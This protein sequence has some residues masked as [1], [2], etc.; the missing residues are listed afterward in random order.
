M[1]QELE[2][3]LSDRVSPHFKR[4]TF[5]SNCIF[6]SPCNRQ[7]SCLLGFMFGHLVANRL[8]VDIATLQIHTIRIFQMLQC[9][10]LKKKSGVCVCTCGVGTIC[11][12]QF[13]P[14]TMWIWSSG[15]ASPPP[16][17]SSSSPLLFSISR[18]SPL[19]PASPLLL[20]CPL[21]PL[22]TVLGMEPRAF[23]C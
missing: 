18:V 1:R 4:K 10:T 23:T 17:L 13:C 2:A 22:F 11:R 12:S 14:S 8:V 20:P 6:L 19:L 3:S 5:K 21:L 15:L 16:L 7:L 9:T